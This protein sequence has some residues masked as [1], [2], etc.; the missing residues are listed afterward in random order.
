MSSIWA[1][2]LTEN[3]AAKLILIA[4]L[5]LF[6]CD[7]SRP[8]AHITPSVT[9]NKSSA[10]M[11]SPV[12]VIYTFRTSSDFP[13]LRKDLIVFVHFRDPSG[14]IRFVDDHNPPTRTNQ[15]RPGNTYTYV[16]T[17]FLPENIP[18]GQYKVQLGLYTPSGKGER[19][20]LNA[21]QN[22]DRTY[23]VGSI[24]IVEPND[25]MQYVS[26]WYDLEREPNDNWYHWRWIGKSAVATV[27]NPRTDALLYLKAES[28]RHRFPEPQRISIIV[29]D[30][31]INQFEMDSSEAFA[32]KFEIPA[33]SLGNDPDVK[34]KLE[35]DR[36]FSPSPDG[37]SGDTRQLGLRV[38]CLYLGRK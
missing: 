15:W 7:A 2:R 34:L 24:K 31:V 20:V 18:V 38:Y 3:L 36:T 35:V 12:E 5:F 4:S 22:N 27:P 16:R 37:K 8:R 14:T 17:Y 21:K 19:F 10:E 1:K 26:G 30:K 13:G 29:G 33:A 25:K 32:K 6:S 28:E 9:F 11:G 23:E